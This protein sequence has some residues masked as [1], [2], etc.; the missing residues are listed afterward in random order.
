[1]TELTP[2]RADELSVRAEQFYNPNLPYHH[3]GHAQDVT[4]NVDVILDKFLG[5]ARKFGPAM[6][7]DRGPIYLA[8][9]HHDDL[10]DSPDN[11]LYESK[12][13]YAALIAGQELDGELG[14]ETI[15][16]IQA[17]ILATEFQAPRK[18]IGEKVLHYADVWGMAVEYGLFLDQNVRLWQEAGR[19]PWE[20]YKKRARKI[21]SI[22]IDESVREFSPMTAA[23]G[24]DPYF[25]PIHARTNL[26]RFVSE[27]EPTS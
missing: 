18:T 4:R 22:T 12:E 23:W 25:F 2:Q 19:P 10:H 15:E 3:W 11:K 8:A 13:H 1:M 7:I 14:T 5:G 9:A 21:I 26:E 20:G 16:Y 17:M 27:S 24:A 6:R